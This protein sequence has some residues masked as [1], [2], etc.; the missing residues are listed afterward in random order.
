MDT[1]KRRIAV[2]IC[3]CLAILVLILIRPGQHKRL[4]KESRTALHTLVA[5]TVLSPSEERARKAIDLAY[6]ELERLGRL[7]NFYATDS[8]LSLINKNAG[9]EPVKVASDTLEIIQAAISVGDATAGGF[10]VTVGP[11]VR[12]WDFNTKT[13]PTAAQVAQ[14]L[15]LVGYKN[16][17]VDAKASTVFLKNAGTQ[18]DLGGIIKGFAADKAAE[19]LKKNGIED[20]I[21]A[22]AGD[23]I[24]FGRQ[25]DGQPW[26][27]G[28]QNP[29]QKGE[30]DQ[31]LA[32]VDLEAKGISTSG[33]YQRF[34]MEDGV[35]YHHLLNPATGF[36]QNL[37]QSVTIVASTA[38]MSDALATGIFV[39]G[40]DK[41]LAAL[42]KLAIEGI[43]VAE[44]GQVLMTDGIKKAVHLLPQK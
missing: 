22:V 10:D 31:L 42:A 36:P 29:R 21:V 43:I 1:P 8:E 6:Q 41:G 9:V 15:P 37:C 12:L 33:D 27:I 28:I 25:P 23:I 35:R 17:V 14:Q 38:A 30:D 34:F 32:T 39:L 16:I 20:G 4:F 26:H 19:I 7:L 44:N 18:I 24:T 40:P 2:V 13:R 5:I 3:C 11:L